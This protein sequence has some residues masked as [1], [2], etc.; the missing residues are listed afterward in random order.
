MIWFFERPG[1][2]L[3]ITTVRDSATSEFVLIIHREPGVDQ[4]ERFATEA[5]FTIR[6][7]DLEAQ[8]RDGEWNL[9]RTSLLEDVLK[10]N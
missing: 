5:A 9:G 3:R 8:L 7:A 6:I 10:L 4:I 2:R 1:E